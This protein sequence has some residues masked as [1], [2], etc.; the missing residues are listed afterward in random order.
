MAD[1]A[2]S[3]SAM[4]NDAEEEVTRGCFDTEGDGATSAV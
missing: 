4:K 3:F 1:D 2:L